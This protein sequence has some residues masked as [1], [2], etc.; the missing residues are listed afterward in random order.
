MRLIKLPDRKNFQKAKGHHQQMEFIGWTWVA[1][2]QIGSGCKVHMKADELPE[3]EVLVRLSRH[4]SAMVNGVIYDTYDP[5][6]EGTRC[7]YGYWHNG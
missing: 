5:S 2:M 7:V 4:Y 3:G 6:R 1:T